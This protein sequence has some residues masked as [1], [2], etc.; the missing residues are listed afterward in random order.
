ML[1]WEVP[2]ARF[3]EEELARRYRD[4]APATLALL[5]GRCEAITEELFRVDAQLKAVLDVAS[6]R[7]AGRLTSHCEADACT[8]PP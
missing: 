7:R 5:Q 3:L 1:T 8:M 4:A 6:L 2:L